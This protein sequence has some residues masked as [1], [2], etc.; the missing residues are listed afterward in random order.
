MTNKVMN[1]VKRYL[2]ILLGFTLLACSV[3]GIIAGLPGEPEAPS[4]VKPALVMAPPDATPTSTPFLPMPPTPTYLPTAFPTPTPFISPTPEMSS[5]APK[6]WSDYPGPTIWPDI[7]IPPPV[8]IFPQP[9]GQINILLLGSDQRPYTG[10]FRTDTIILLTL[11][12]SQGTANMT[13]FPRDLYVY[14]PGWTVQRINTAFGYGGFNAL[15]TTLEYNFGVRPDHYVLINFWSFVDVINSLGGLNVHVGRTL[16]DHRDGYGH[17][18]ANTGWVPMDGDTALWYVRSRYSTS[19]FDRGRR[20][21]EVVQAGFNKLISLDAIK[22]APELYEIYKQS[23]T[24]D[25]TIEDMSALLPLATKLSDLSSIQHYYIGPQQV[26]NW[27]NS[28]GA[29]VLLPIREAVLDVMRQALNSD[30]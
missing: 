28:R 10:G 29:M 16:C 30:H 14:I 15:A 6:T 25:M 3:P 13:S 21:Q 24:M 26:S 19:D 9:A 11:N 17:Y 5:G 12:P 2:P 18:C 20:Q 4:S 27:I 23:V 1:V 7:D 22:R 8:G